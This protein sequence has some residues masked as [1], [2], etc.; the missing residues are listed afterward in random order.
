M[1]DWHK[2]PRAYGIALA[3]MVIAV[4]TALVVVCL[5]KYRYDSFDNQVPQAKGQLRVA[6]QLPRSGGAGVGFFGL[7][8]RPLEHHLL[9]SSGFGRIYH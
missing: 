3:D 6:L 5:G 8:V 1:D 9:N 4:P 7:G 2:E